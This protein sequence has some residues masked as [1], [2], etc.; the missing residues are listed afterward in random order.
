MVHPT[1]HAPGATMRKGGEGLL[2]GQG[3]TTVREWRGQFLVGKVQAMMGK[4]EGRLCL[5]RARQFWGVSGCWRR[6]RWSHLQGAAASPCTASVRTA[7]LWG[8]PTLQLV[9]R[10]CCSRAC[11]TPAQS[12]QSGPQ[13]CAPTARRTV[14]EIVPPARLG[15]WGRQLAGTL[16]DVQRA[17]PREMAWDKDTVSVREHRACGL[18]LG[19]SLPKKVQLGEEEQ[20]WVEG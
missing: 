9:A 12:P 17:A 7:R 4:W 5:G 19:Q 20:H 2:Q 11:C 1:P 8:P 10:A 14:G 13:A 6:S 15:Q 16:L 18:F 3:W